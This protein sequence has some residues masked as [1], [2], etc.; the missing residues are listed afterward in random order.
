[1]LLPLVYGCLFWKLFKFLL[2]YYYYHQAQDA[3]L[4]AAIG[5]SWWKLSSVTWYFCQIAL[6]KDCYN[7]ACHIMWVAIGFSLHCVASCSKIDGCDSVCWRILTLIFACCCLF[8]KLSWIPSF[9]YVPIQSFKGN[10]RISILICSY[11]Y[12]LL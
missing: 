4:I 1:M 3:L 11:M 12:F 9:V 8:C 5:Y 2:L 7:K 6:T 10:V